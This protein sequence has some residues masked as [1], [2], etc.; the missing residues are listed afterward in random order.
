M[1]E[2]EARGLKGVQRFSRGLQVFQKF[3]KG[4]KGFKVSKVSKFQGSKFKVQVPGSLVLV[5]GPW[6]CPGPG[7][8][9]FDPIRI[10]I[11]SYPIYGIRI[12]SFVC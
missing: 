7:P 6:S 1:C 12:W 9:L 5:P 10:L 2:R 3:Q 4:F 11:G 8:V